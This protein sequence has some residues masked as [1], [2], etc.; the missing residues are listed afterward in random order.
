MAHEQ[1]VGILGVG[2]YL[3]PDV[4]TNDWW[5]REVVE[6]WTDRQAAPFDERAR[7]EPRTNGQQAIAD[8]MAAL[9]DD[10]FHGARQRRV[11]PTGMRASEM[12]S[13]AARIAIERAGID[14]AEIGLLLCNT[15]APDH[16][17]TNNACLLHETLKLGG[18]CLAMGTEAACNALMCQ[19]ALAEPMIR[20]GR[21]RY[22]LLLQTCNITPL[23]EMDQP[24]SALFGDGCSAVVVGAVARDG[25]LLA[26]AHRTDGSFHCA[27]VAGIPDRRWYEEG[28][29]RIYT[30]SHELSRRSFLGIA[31][32]AAALTEEALVMAGCSPADIDFFAP[33][34]PTPWARPLLQQRLGLHKARF[35]DT[36]SWAGSMFG[37]NIPVALAMAEQDGL[38]RQGDLVLT[39]AGGAGLTYS[40]M[41]FRW[42]K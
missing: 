13:R 29:V 22:A 18:R 10:P 5:P 34:Q 35:V 28:R 7:V 16:L 41:V 37:A 40:S 39:F 17:V 14:P 27:I 30:P 2:T 26:H 9:R 11:M 32:T 4:R 25:G 1:N 12:E 20:S 38:L 33:H 15:L 8:A 6:R 42:G 23:L 21:I 24:H 3:P 36:F 31:D 19:L